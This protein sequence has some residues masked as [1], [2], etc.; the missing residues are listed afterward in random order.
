MDILISLGAAFAVSVAM[1]TV[2]WYFLR[3]K[4]I[5]SPDPESKF[6]DY[7]LFRARWILGGKLLL[8]KEFFAPLAP[9]YCYVIK[10]KDGDGIADYKALVVSAGRAS[11][12]E[13]EDL[14]DL[15]R[16]AYV[17]ALQQWYAMQA[18]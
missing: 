18:T 3:P 6:K 11:R 1:T 4:Q 10:D 17:Y 7:S 14:D 9:F 16:E 15:D 5:W 13:E 2:W 8:R 12:T